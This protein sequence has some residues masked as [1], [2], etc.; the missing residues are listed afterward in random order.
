MMK[1]FFIPFFVLCYFT[2]YSQNTF[3]KAEKIMKF[4]SQAG[5]MICIDDTIYCY[6]NGTDSFA[7]RNYCVYLGKYDL[8]GNLL[9]RHYDYNYFYSYYLNSKNDIFVSSDTMIIGSSISRNLEF[10]GCLLM[11]NKSKGNIVK[12]ICYN[13]KVDDFEFY[14]GM[15]KVND[16]IYAVL[17][18]VNEY[19]NKHKLNSQ[20]SLI[21]IR[22]GSIKYINFGIDGV[23]DLPRCIIW[24]GEKL[25]VGAS[26]WIP[27]W[28]FSN[29]YKK[30][31][32]IGLIYEIDTSG[33]WKKVF[34]SLPDYSL[35]FK[36][37][38]DANGDYLCVGLRHEWT[39]DISNYNKWYWHNRFVIMK[40]KKE[41]YSLEWIKLVG[42]SYDFKYDFEINNILPAVEGGGYVVAGYFPN[43]PWDYSDQQ[44]DSM[45]ATGN[46]A[47]VVGFLQKVTEN[48]D[49]LWLRTYGYINDTSCYI[50]EWHNIRSVV[51]SPDNG[52]I[53]YGDLAYCP[54]EGDTATNWP[55]WLLKVDQYGCLVPG[56]QNGDTV[57]VTEETSQNELLIYPNP[58]SDVVYIYDEKG[59]DSKYTIADIKGKIHRKWS[60][61][62]KDH[63]YIVQLHDFS[64][65]VYI[66][67]RVDDGGRMRSEKFVKGR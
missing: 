61:N 35:P 43:F 16:S 17:S 63:T 8:K 14:K 39:R 49:S 30:V 40:L 7:F 3:N 54:Q 25:L 51:L 32:G 59:G 4:I 33:T 26:Y 65:G 10:E 67:S 56:C 21:N 52:Y 58:S 27:E 41:T 9:S 45:E 20:I 36:I 62:L 24:N 19:D 37:L 55:A 50:K 57:S 23:S 66:V 11:F 42:S 22:S 1:R 2:I 13:S 48:G 15:A 29:P 60:G 28:D 47:K 46:A 38:I 5:P 64:P 34:S 31:T 53:L 6:G 44:L 18:S 12:R